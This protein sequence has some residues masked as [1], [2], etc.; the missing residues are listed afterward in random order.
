M[1]TGRDIIVIGGSAGAIQ[2]L[3]AILRGL[4]PDLPASIFVV[5]HRA[6]RE[7]NLLPSILDAAGPLPVVIASEGQSFAPGCVYVPPNDRHLLV[8]SDHVHVRRGPHEN[9]SR[10]AIDPLFRSAAAHATTRVIGVVLSGLLSDGTAGLLA[11]KRCGG[12]ALVQDPGGA[13]YEFDAAQCPRPCRGRHGA[14]GAGHGRPSDG[15]LR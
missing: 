3:C 9:R 11:I 8:G 13:A 10:P 2:P 4:T 12:L 15:A 1:S 7:P 14:A 5:I 6:D